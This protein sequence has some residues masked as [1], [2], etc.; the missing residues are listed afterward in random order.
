MQQAAQ[1]P[2]SE[3]L[4]DAA[5]DLLLQLVDEVDAKVRTVQSV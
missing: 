4:P 5:V 1:Q 2:G 3:R